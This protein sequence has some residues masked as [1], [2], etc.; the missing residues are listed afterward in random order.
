[1]LNITNFIIQMQDYPKLLK[2]GDRVGITQLDRLYCFSTCKNDLGT[3]CLKFKDNL[4][5][6]CAGSCEQDYYTLNRALLKMSG[7]SIEEPSAESNQV[8]EGIQINF[9]ARVK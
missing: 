9:G 3:A 6:E 8:F 4:P 1:M 2:S 5:Q 7:V